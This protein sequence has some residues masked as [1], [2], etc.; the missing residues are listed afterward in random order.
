MHTAQNCRSICALL[1]FS[2]LI[3]AYA[4]A[5]SGIAYDQIPDRWG[6][7]QQVALM[8]RIFQGD[9]GTTFKEVSSNFAYYGILI[10]GPAYALELAARNTNIADPEYIFTLALH[11]AS[12]SCYLITN[13]FVY[14]ILR[15]LR[16]NDHD[17]FIGTI[18]LA[19]Y[20]IWL[21]HSFFNHKDVPTAAFFVIATFAT[22]SIAGSSEKSPNYGSVALLILAT[23]LLGGL[24][25]AAVGLTL[26]CWIIVTTIL[27]IRRQYI[28][29]LNSITAT[30]ILVYVIT[31]MAWME[32]IAFVQG[33]LAEMIN[34]SWNMCTRTN[35]FCIYPHSEEWSAAL[36]LWHWFLVQTPIPVLLGVLIFLLH[37]IIVPDRTR[38]FLIAIIAW[39]LF[40]VML[41]NSVVYDGLRHFLFVFPLIFVAAV[42]MWS[43]ILNYLSRYAF[44]TITTFICILFLYDNIAL[45]PYNYSWF[46]I[47]SRQYIDESIFDTD[48]WG[49]S[50]Y[51][52]VRLPTDV[53]AAIP[54]VGVVDHLAPYTRNRQ[55]LWRYD[56]LPSGTEFVMI[57]LTR[58]PNLPDMCAPPQHVIRKLPF[59]QKELKLSYASKCT[60]P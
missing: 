43:K 1:G 5:I 22:L 13:I 7:E 28:L 37:S 52:A 42:T 24:K 18:M 60:V 50:L 54:I 10:T 48:Y 3:F 31:P 39:P 57:N 27:A 51:E 9:F 29:L 4:Q 21:G 25:I 17:A 34:H 15:C 11:S 41:R 44:Q 32:P 14:L 45:F 40:F 55:L 30:V 46:N 2:I 36:Y 38:L 58:W 35:N 12:F 49:L 20:P 47:I 33:S 59:T 56:G 53:N 23:A 19:L 26:P 16:V 8:A 6:V